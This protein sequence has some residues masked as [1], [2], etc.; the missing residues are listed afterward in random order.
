MNARHPDA[1]TTVEEPVTPSAVR[2]FFALV[3]DEQVRNSLVSL[4]RDVARRSRG[5]AVSGEHV[6]LT[7]AFLGDISADRVP[8]LQKIGDQ[9]AHR[10]AVLS[11][12]TL[13]AWRAS[14]V[15]WVAP[16]TV[17]SS[18]LTLHAELGAALA[19]GGFTIEARAFR[20]HIT[21]ARRCV[22]P[23]P[24]ARATPIDWR[25]DRLVLIGSELR[26]EGPRYRELATWPLLL[27]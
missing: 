25:V 20:P 26:A 3:P 11:F 14:G 10:G 6:H 23:M 8:A 5:R 4:S 16:S 18:L 21:L 24:R 17:P 13:G 15:A 7:V 12:D 9:V 22:T 19:E 27:Q 2:V 1:T